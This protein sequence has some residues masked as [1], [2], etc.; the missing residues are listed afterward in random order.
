MVRRTLL[1]LSPLLLLVA[2]GCGGGVA[3]ARVSGKVT[4]KGE[5]I[6][7][8]KIYFMPDGKKGNTGPT[9]F[10]DIVNGSYDTGS[11]NGRGAIKGALIVAIEGHDPDQQ[12]K[13]EKGDTSGETT[14]KSLFPRYET[15]MEMGDG[16]TTKDFDVPADAAKQKPGGSGPI[17]P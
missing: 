14:L 11:S 13:T 12:N 16:A 3:T 2:A 4:F 17:I 1:Q 6:K 9:G 15:T 7:A 5:P 10:A 8:G